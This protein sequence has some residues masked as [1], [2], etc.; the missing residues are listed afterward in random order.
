MLDIIGEPKR[1]WEDNISMD[2]KEIIINIR[3][4]VNSA[5]DRDYWRAPVNAK[6]NLR[7]PYVNIP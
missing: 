2:L 4:W 7:V 1:R 3:N 5:H 6:L